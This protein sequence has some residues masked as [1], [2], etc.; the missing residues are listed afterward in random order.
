MSRSP[1]PRLTLLS[2]WADA[3]GRLLFAGHLFTLG[4]GAD[5][6]LAL[7]VPESLADSLLKRM[8]M[9]VLRAKV[10]IGAVR[11]RGVR[12]VRASKPV[13][14]GTGQQLRI[15]DETARAACSSVRHRDPGTADDSQQA[16]NDWL[17]ADI[18]AGIPDIGTA[19]SGEFIPQM[20]NLDL[21]NAISF[22]KGCYTG[23]EIIA[24]TKYLGRVKRRMLRFSARQR[25]HR[26]PAHRSMPHAAQSDRW[27]VPPP[28]LKA[29]NCWPSSR[30]TTCR[31]PSFWTATD[32]GCC[33]ASICPTRCR[34]EPCPAGVPTGAASAFQQQG[35]R[36]Q[37]REHRTGQHADL[38]PRFHSPGP[39]PRR[40]ASR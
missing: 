27:S 17:L 32:P 23:Q 21:L 6:P 40:P 25:L 10:Q 31:A 1:A 9:Y 26:P 34:F 30:S 29:A 19:T 39:D 37:R 16:R 18:R 15:S 12:P 4:T 33:S 22:S 5:A 7:L 38:Q 24:R 36:D 3:R 35:C 20:V 14:T 28:H 2:G 11:S 13:D 8:Q